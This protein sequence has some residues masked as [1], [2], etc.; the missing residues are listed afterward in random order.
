MR[1]S[2][3]RVWSLS[4]I[5]IRLVILALAAVLLMA[6]QQTGHLKVVQGMVAQLTSPAQ[7]SMS[8]VAE[9]V[10]GALYGVRELGNL[11]QRAAE[12]E[13][14]NGSL[15]VENLRL[16]EVERE[17]ERLRNLLAFAETRPALELRGGQIIARVIGHDGNNFLNYIMIDLGSRHGIGVGMPVVT[18]Q[19]LV[20]RVSEVTDIT[21]KVL[22]IIDPSSTVNAIL[23]SSRL[24]GVV[25]GRPGADPVMDFIQQGSEI[26]IGEIVL[27]SGLGG[28]FPKGI[29]I[30]Q[31]TEIRQRDFEIRQQALVQPTVDFGRLEL[32]MVVTNFDPLE[33]VPELAP[34]V[35]DESVD[36]DA[37]PTMPV[38]PNMDGVL[39]P[40]PEEDSSG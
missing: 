21:A 16:R 1:D 38:E 25:N 18:D 14:I 20:G 37:D 13:R 6:L 10:S 24:T 23:Q 15:L 34:I 39:A 19:G 3:R 40:E 31:V 8:G 17:N 29:P 35:P 11:Q 9:G 28:N 2:E 4:D 27:T 36:P 5:G 22:L 32:V 7:L 33:I 30:G 26:G 12:L